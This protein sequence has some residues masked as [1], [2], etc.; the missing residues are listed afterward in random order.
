MSDTDRPA[1]RGEPEPGLWRSRRAHQG[2][3]DLDPFLAIPL[4][5]LRIDTTTGFN[6]Y[7]RSMRSGAPVLYRSGDLKF[8]D[9]HRER[10]QRNGVK[11]LYIAADDRRRYLRYL[12]G[13]LS[14]VLEDE[15]IAPSE[16]ARILYTSANLL[17]E[18]VFEDPTLGS[19]I[20]RVHGFVDNTVNY[21][22]DKAERFSDL[23]R[24][25]SF[26]YHVYTHSVNVCIF[27]VAL[28][29][30]LGF[31][32]TQI[33][34]LGVGLL[35]HDAGK[36]AIDPRILEKSGPLIPQ[37]WEIMK[38]HPGK[39]YEMLVKSGA[40]EPESLTVVLQHHEQC[41]GSGYPFGLA[42][43][44][45]HSFAKIAAV[46]DVFDALTTERTYKNAIS[47]FPAIRIMQTE[48]AGALDRRILRELVLLLHASQDEADQSQIAESLRRRAEDNAA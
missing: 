3:P 36:A 8:T 14:H 12:E 25:M 5:S 23:L 29:R 19:T 33:N 22:F 46:A 18:N 34:R 16:K 7:L 20:A 11:E 6:L 43:D 2:Q 30:R 40:V 32:Q 35:L 38:T 31:G 15:S 44:Q 41:S 26:N 48:M 21:M 39:G 4:Q 1:D 10:L 45:I 27:G 37:E 9:A 17:I 47:S 24:I 42:A 13:H 28:A